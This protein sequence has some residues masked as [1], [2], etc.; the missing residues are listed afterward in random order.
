MVDWLD[1][2]V[3]A[4]SILAGAGSLHQEGLPEKAMPANR[5]YPIS[6]RRDDPRL[7]TMRTRPERAGPAR[8]DVPPV[9]VGNAGHGVIWRLP[10]RDEP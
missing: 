7:V 9:T 8:P 10:R 2:D 6:P 4:A 3:P 1:F 5:S